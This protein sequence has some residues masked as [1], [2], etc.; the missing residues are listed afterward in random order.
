MDE[1]PEIQELADRW[2]AAQQEGQ[3]ISTED[4]CRDCPEL[5]DAVKEA[6]ADRK[7]AAEYEEWAG[8]D[9]QQAASFFAGFRQQPIRQ[10]SA[11]DEFGGR[12]KLEEFLEVGGSGEV[13]RAFDPRIGRDVA[14]KIMPRG[15]RS[16]DEA[17]TV[18]QL[19]HPNIVPVHDVGSRDECDYIVYALIDGPSLAQRLEQGRLS[20]EEAVRIAAEVADA[21]HHAHSK[22]FI[23]RDVKPGNILLSKDGRV[24]L[25]DFG[26]AIA[27]DQSIDRDDALR[28]T[29][30]YKSPEQVRGDSHLIDRRIDIYSLGVV[31]FEMLTGRRPY[32]GDR[33]VVREDI[34]IADPPNP[35]TYDKSISEEVATLCLKCLEKDPGKRYESASDLA[36][37]L[38]IYLPG[39]RLNFAWRWCRRHPVLF[40]LPVI[41]LAMLAT[42]VIS[43][44][45]VSY[46]QTKQ[47]GEY[48]VWASGVLGQVIA[49]YS[50]EQNGLA[51]AEAMGTIDP[52]YLSPTVYAQYAKIYKETLMNCPPDSQANRA[53]IMASVKKRLRSDF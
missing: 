41:L 36:D 4:L 38:R 8:V 34:L 43:Y 7:F 30:P 6:I 31:L 10:H 21:L 27:A 48:N 9:S 39:G 14:I 17:K 44:A 18:G 32:R 1:D 53:R 15:E 49:D 19:G 16:L 35:Q 20:K 52:A 26:I 51:M 2:E 28:G 40:S 13:W 33:S 12:Y 50:K 25:T 11:G 29:L 46:H 22:G 24:F 5:L 23:H 42:L 45:S 47:L 37:E 3:P